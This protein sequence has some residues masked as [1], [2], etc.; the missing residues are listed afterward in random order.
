MTFSMILEN[1]AKY[2]NSTPPYSRENHCSS[3]AS[4]GSV[5][6]YKCLSIKFI[7]LFRIQGKIIDYFVIIFAVHSNNLTKT[8]FAVIDP[9]FDKSGAINFGPLKESEYQNFKCK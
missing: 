9:A 4:S 3:F 2:I 7:S 8:R 5:A 1:P 6:I